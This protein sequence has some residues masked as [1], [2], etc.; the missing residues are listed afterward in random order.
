[1]ERES[2]C[3]MKW[4]K[5]KLNVVKHRILFSGTNTSDEEGTNTRQ[6]IGTGRNTVVKN[7]SAK[8]I[9]LESLGE[10]YQIE[11][12]RR[13]ISSQGLFPTRA[14]C[15][16]C[17]IVD[18]FNMIFFALNRA[19]CISCIGVIIIAISILIIVI[20]IIAFITQPN[21]SIVLY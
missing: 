11:E 6:N 15:I 12:H 1:M 9:F 16:S 2:L 20:V 14:L 13:E 19:L 10:S 4:K 3:F 5:P 17:I 21:F 8:K 7:W 18:F